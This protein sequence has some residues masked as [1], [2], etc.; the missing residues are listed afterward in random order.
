MR[1]KAY[2]GFAMSI[3]GRFSKGSARERLLEEALYNQVNAE[4]KNGIIRD[5]LW[6]KAFVE[7]DGDEL[8]AK[9]LYC[10]LR[11]QS[12]KDEI[13]VSQQIVASAEKQRQQQEMS[14]VARDKAIGGRF[15]SIKDEIYASQQRAEKDRKKRGNKF[16]E[17]CRTEYNKNWARCPNCR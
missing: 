9:V 17:Q 11:I 13:Y 8:R 4:I 7:A 16:C 3:F 1:H 6:T 14:M 2:R 10:E 15:Q 12:I 5:G